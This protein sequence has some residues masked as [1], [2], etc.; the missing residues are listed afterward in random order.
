[1]NF[2]QALIV[3]SAPVGHHFEHYAMLIRATDMLIAADGGVNLCLAAGRVPDVCVGD[4]DS[5]APETLERAAA[6]GAEIRRFPVSKDVSDLDLALDV[7]REA[8]VGRVS[9]IAAFSGRLDHTLAGL[10]TLLGAADLDAT[11]DEGDWMA[12]ALDATSR[13]EL[14]LA[15]QPGTVISVMA[16][17]D[18]ARVS[19]GGVAY[20]LADHQL[21]PLSSLGLSNVAVEPAQRVAVSAGRAIV[22]ANRATEARIAT[23]RPPQ[24][25]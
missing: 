17:G 3:G 25:R 10:G 23:V 2:R 21:L 19:I 22:I 20:P 8:H 15:E 24:S 12:F 4:F 6:L 14:D 5:T 11:A 18:G 1:M 16:V 9:F 7:A 13:C